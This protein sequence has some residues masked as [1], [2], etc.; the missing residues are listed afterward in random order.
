MNIVN[1]NISALSTILPL[2]AE[3]EISPLARLFH[4]TTTSYKF[5]FFLSLLDILKRNKFEPGEPILFRDLTVEMLANSWYPH[6]YFRLSFGRQDQI[7]AKLDALPLEIGEPIL[8]FRDPDK[9]LLRATIGRHALDHSLMR[10]V[11]FRLLRPFF[12]DELR[13]MPDHKVDAAIIRLT[14]RDCGARAPLYSFSDQRD[15]ILP[16]PLWTE[17]L[18]LHFSLIQGWAAWHWLEYMQRCNRAVPAISAK[19]FPPQE[20]SSLRPQ[21]EYWK[22][23]IQLQDLKCIYTDSALNPDRLSLDHFLPWSFVAHD[24][25]WNL[26]PTFPEINSSKLDHLP[27]ETYCRR[28]ARLQHQGLVLTSQRMPQSRWERVVEPFLADLKLADRGELL[29]ERK[30]TAAYESCVKPQLAIAKSLG[31]T[32]NWRYQTGAGGGGGS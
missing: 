14:K 3:L 32:P 10:F 31:F 20:R 2:N 28:L 23:V 16:H 9:K 19:L 15:A 11:P 29:D 26:V 4:E 12:E 25:L 17:Y 5:V 27:A 18:R 6:T 21:I 13:G 1:D 30:L 22:L 7:T 24:Q 8:K